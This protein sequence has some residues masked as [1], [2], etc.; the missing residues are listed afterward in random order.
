MAKKIETSVEKKLRA[1]YDLQL[2]DSRI[3]ELI[4]L[5]GEL[6][7]EVEALEN[8]ISSLTTKHDKIKEE[9]Q[10]SENGILTF[11]FTIKN[12]L[13]TSF[14]TLKAAKN[15]RIKLLEY[16]KNFFDDQIDLN[17]KRTK[18]I[19]FGKL[20]DKSTVFHLADLL[21]SHKIKFNNITNCQLKNKQKDWSGKSICASQS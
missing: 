12:Q 21:N 2:I 16:M 3:D 7:L 8:E 19:V 6:P 11:P 20:K 4:S 10:E 15:M 13:V 17:S 1:L 5:R 14:S 9:I 18:N